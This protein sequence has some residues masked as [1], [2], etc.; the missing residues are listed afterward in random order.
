M[1]AGAFVVNVLSYAFNVLI[2]RQLGR[3]AFGEFSALVSIVYLVSV[4]SSVF[5]TIVVKYSAILSARNDYS[6]IRDLV[7][8]MTRYASFVIITFFAIS[9]AFHNQIL[10]ALKLDDFLLI[11]LLNGVFAIML[12]QA[13]LNAALQGL[14]KFSILN[15]YGSSLILI[16]ILIASI[17]ISL[18]LGIAGVF[19]GMILSGIIIYI[20]CWIS[21]QNSINKADIKSKSFPHQVITFFKKIFSRTDK[22]LHSMRND[23]IHFSPFS[24]LTALGLALLVQ[25]DIILAKVFFSPE[26]AGTYASLALIC[27]VIP[28]FTLPLVAVMFPQLTK[29]VEQKKNFIPLFSIVI[30]IVT[31]CSTAIA[32]V[33]MIF[34]DLI[35][36]AFSLGSNTFAPSIPYIGIFSIFQLSYAVLNTFVTFFLS[37]GKNIQAAGIV[38]AGILQAVGMIFFHKSLTQFITVSITICLAFIIWYIITT[39]QLYLKLKNKN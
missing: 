30:V 2:G 20:F 24:T 34:P 21:I 8:M 18:G 23:I 10:S 19:W 31:A 1:F 32:A 17:L 37:I 28:F 16:R 7:I 12:P 5:A 36:K 14:E 29:L 39:A 38:F 11:I 9:L 3:V 13:I 27:K 4:V 25:N 15:I 22:D 33:Y 6:R 26:D 35:V